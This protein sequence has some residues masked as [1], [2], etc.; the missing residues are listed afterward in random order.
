[1]SVFERELSEAEVAV[2]LA[3]PRFL[4]GPPPPVMKHR[5]V[6]STVAMF[7][8]EPMR[9]WLMSHSRWQA[10]ALAQAWKSDPQ[11]LGIFGGITG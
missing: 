5:A 7:G 1:M 9:S 3:G 8:E 6:G 2:L 4:P 11:V 10:L